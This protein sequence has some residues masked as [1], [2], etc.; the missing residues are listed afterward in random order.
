MAMVKSNGCCL[1]TDGGNVVAVYPSRNAALTHLTQVK[2]NWRTEEPG[3][4]LNDA[5]F[6]NYVPD[7]VD[8][9]NCGCEVEA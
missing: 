2:P 7:I 9:P 4:W 3:L 6:Y 8:C 1:M 5:P